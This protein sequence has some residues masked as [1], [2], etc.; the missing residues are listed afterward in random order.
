MDYIEMLEQY[1]NVLGQLRRARRLLEDLDVFDTGSHAACRT[2][3]NHYEKTERT[4]V[5]SNN[6]RP[7][8][9]ILSNI[10]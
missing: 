9:L 3:G 8:Q 5:F 6:V 2:G 7:F 4:A 10:F 1:Q